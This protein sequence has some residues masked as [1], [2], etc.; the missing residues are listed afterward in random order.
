MGVEPS[1]HRVVD[2]RRIGIFYAFEEE[3]R[4]IGFSEY[5]ILK[6]SELRLFVL[7]DPA[8]LVGAELCV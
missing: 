8:T 2:S 4:S 1:S 6:K 5:S 3:I 7:R